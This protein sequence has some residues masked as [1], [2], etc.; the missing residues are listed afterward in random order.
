MKIFY[1][2]FTLIILC[3]FIVFSCTEQEKV[4]P[5]SDPTLDGNLYGDKLTTCEIN[6]AI[7]TNDLVKADWIRNTV[8]E[9]NNKGSYVHFT[10]TPLGNHNFLIRTSSKENFEST[11]GQGIFKFSS[12]Q[13]SKID[14]S[15]IELNEYFN[16]TEAEVKK[17]IA[18]RIGQLLRLKFDNADSKSVMNPDIN[19]P[20]SGLSSGDIKTLQ[21][22]Y[23]S[24]S[25]TASITKG[26][27]SARSIVLK[28]NTTNPNELN[29]RGSGLCWSRTN[30][31]PTVSD[32]KN[33][34]ENQTASV[35]GTGWNSPGTTVYFR[36]YV[37]TDCETIYSPVLKIDV[38]QADTWELSSSIPFQTRTG[39]QVITT[40]GLFGKA[41]IIGGKFS[42]GEL[43]N[44]V[45]M[46]YPANA[47]WKQM[48]SFPGARRENA[49]SFLYQ[50]KIYYGLGYVAS[51]FNYPVDWWE[52]NIS[53]D[54]WT[55]KNNFS[56]VGRPG[57]IGLQLVNGGLITLGLDT[58]T[59]L[60][61]TTTMGYNAQQDRWFYLSNFPIANGVKGFAN[62]SGFA[63]TLSNNNSFYTYNIGGN[64]WSQLASFPFDTPTVS[65]GNQSNTLASIGGKLYYGSKSQVSWTMYNA[66]TNSW[67]RKKNCPILF[68]T[69]TVLYT[70]GDKIYAFGGN[71]DGVWEYN[72]E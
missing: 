17:V 59:A 55:Q 16:W 3:F 38:P 63:Y 31:Q 49:V 39:S 14:T 41:F 48:K 32:E 44:E 21:S 2:S 71:N 52:Y 13:I 43:T 15:Q 27:I 12:Y 66:A 22:L 64:F 29:I 53:S 23:G 8:S 47:E 18:Y 11:D 56:A 30:T 26:P 1:K 36:S 4:K 50:D 40:D 33:F 65:T 46:H 67:I 61:N 34:F 62:N 72:G 19:Q 54:V 42:S 24:G 70:V 25:L 69:N 45:W 68:N 20:F 60:I 57:S 6:F 28:W 10:E 51:N 37:V 5:A 7:Q 58:R 35:W 9:F